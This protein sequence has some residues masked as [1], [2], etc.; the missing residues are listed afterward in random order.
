MHPSRPNRLCHR[1]RRDCP[2]RRLPCSNGFRNA[3]RRN[4]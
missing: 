1:R 4:R 3:A 2:K